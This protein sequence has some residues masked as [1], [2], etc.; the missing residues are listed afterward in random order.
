MN[1]EERLEALRMSLTQRQMQYILDCKRLEELV[2]PGHTYT[3]TELIK[4]LELA[5]N[6]ATYIAVKTAVEEMTEKVVQELAKRVTEEGFVAVFSSAV[7]PLI[8]REAQLISQ[9]QLKRTSQ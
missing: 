6:V 1:S 5:K 7:E 8:L 2:K 9:R 3:Y 4:S